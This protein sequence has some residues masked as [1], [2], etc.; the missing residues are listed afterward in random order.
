LNHGRH[1]SKS[2][3]LKPTAI[4][5]DMK[6][7]PDQNDVLAENAQLDLQARNLR[8]QLLAKGVSVVAP[9]CAGADI[10]RD[11][12]A[13]KAHVTE[14]EALARSPSAAK[15]TPSK[16]QRENLTA[17]ILKARNVANLDELSRLPL[18][19]D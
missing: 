5:P 11:N 15:A 17:R 18:P 8:A 3:W 4:N 7:L 10:L 1:K 16:G 13:L 12:A 9:Q 2:N 14:L 6:N 19:Q